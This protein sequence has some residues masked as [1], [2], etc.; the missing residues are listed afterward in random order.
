M[1]KLDAI[2]KPARGEYLFSWPGKTFED[3]FASLMDGQIYKVDS[4][5]DNIPEHEVYD[6]WPQVDKADEDEIKQFVD[7]GSFKKVHIDSVTSD[8]VVIDSVRI[9]KWKRDP[10]GSRRVKSRLCARGCF[11]NQRDT[12][13][14]R[15]T[16]AT[17]LSQRILISTAVNHDHDA[18]SWDVSGAFL[19]GLTFEKVRELLASRGISSPVRKVVIIAPANVWRHLAKFDASFKV[20]FDRLGD[21]ALLCIKPVYGLN[22]AP[23]AWQLCLHGHW[24]EQGGVPS[25]LDENYFIW[26]LPK[27]ETASVT[28]HVDD[29]GAEGSRQWLDQQYKLLVKKFGKV[30]RQTLPF[31]HCGVVYK[32][33][34]DGICMTQDDFCRKLKPV[35]IAKNKKDEEALTPGELTSFRSILGGLLWLTATRLDLVSDVCALQSQVTKATI[36]HLR[37]ANNVVKKAQ[38]ELGQNLGLYFRKLLPPLRLACVHDSS[39]AGNVRNYAQEGVMVLLT[40]DRLSG[41]EGSYEHVLQDNQTCRLGGRCHV[42]WAHGAK[43]KRISYSTSHAETLSAVSGMEA[44]TLVAVRLAELLYSPKKPTIQSLLQLQEGGVPELPVDGYTDCKDLFELMSGD[45]SIPQDK[46]QRLY[47]LSLREA[48]LNGRQR[49]LILTPTGSML[50]DALTKSM[51]APQLMRAL[52]SGMVDY[53]NEGD[54]RMTL[55][56]VPKVDSVKDEHLD[57]TDKE[58]ISSLRASSSAT[59]VCMFMSRSWCFWMVTAAV[60]TSA[61]ATSTTSTSSASSSVSSA[62]PTASSD[63]GWLWLICLSCFIIAAEHGI[64]K[65]LR[66]LWQWFRRVSVIEPDAEPP[67][68]VTLNEDLVEVQLRELRE[69]KLERDRCVQMYDMQFERASRLQRELDEHL[70]ICPLGRNVYVTNSGRAWHT[71]TNCYHIRRYQH[72]TYRFCQDCAG[73]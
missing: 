45:K 10:D 4:E 58:L 2:R 20:D 36:A 56:R 60:A 1:A 21:W 30:T 34:P 17:R 52:S 29:C 33:I 14:T 68:T 12:L 23:L 69:A 24:E 11:D 57:M 22:D 7:T 26:K 37:Q 43:A 42:L 31:T 32:K 64:L 27:N 72:K 8:T 67:A 13:S 73:R 54:H 61:S 55:R 19:K 62:P 9:R 28:T 50:A 47:I 63:D 5:T 44:A 18:E 6:I 25:L 35:E 48:R 59:A 39:A 51:L 49:W 66:V 3:L 16:T 65:F 15:S 46:G 41:F 40:E 53:C 38:A 71:D 70:A